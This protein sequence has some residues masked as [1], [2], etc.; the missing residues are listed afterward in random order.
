MKGILCWKLVTAE[1]FL[2]WEPF[3]AHNV[4]TLYTRMELGKFSFIQVR[5]PSKTG[6]LQQH[7]TFLHVIQFVR[8][9]KKT[10]ASQ[11]SKWQKQWVY[12]LNMR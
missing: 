12:F 9:K 5:S 8:I 2:T 7:A 3:Y 4:S 11:A 10:I 6:R 1:A